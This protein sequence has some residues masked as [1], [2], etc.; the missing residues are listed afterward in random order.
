MEQA[1]EELKKLML[2]LEISIV[3]K[4]LEKLYSLT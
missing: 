1:K 4:E 3:R 2:E